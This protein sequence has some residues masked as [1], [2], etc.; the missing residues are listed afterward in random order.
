MSE[1]RICGSL[2]FEIQEKTVPVSLSSDGPSCLLKSFMTFDASEI[3]T[4]ALPNLFRVSSLSGDG[5]EGKRLVR[6]NPLEIFITA[7][8]CTSCEGVFAAC[9]PM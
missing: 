2:N 6:K 1:L 7:L 5:G 4:P 9:K 8:L 3:S